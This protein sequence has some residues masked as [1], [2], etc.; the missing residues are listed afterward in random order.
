MSDRLVNVAENLAKLIRQASADHR[1]AFPD[2]AWQAVNDRLGWLRLIGINLFPATLGLGNEEAAV[3][4][5]A[6]AK[7]QRE[8]AA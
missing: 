2:G 1:A 3:T 4:L 6:W 7:K 5:E 8:G